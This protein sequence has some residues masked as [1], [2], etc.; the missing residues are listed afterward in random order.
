MVLHAIGMIVL[1]IWAPLRHPMWEASST[2]CK[3]HS[4]T[5][6]STGVWRHAGRQSASDFS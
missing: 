6:G 4:M 3:E 1:L 2:T 5:L